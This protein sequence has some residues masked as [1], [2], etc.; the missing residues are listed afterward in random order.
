MAH[1]RDMEERTLNINALPLALKRAIWLRLPMD[2]RLRCAEVCRSWRDA[3]ADASLWTTLDLSCLPIMEV[4]STL[5]LLNAAARR[6]GGQLARLDLCDYFF[7][8]LCAVWGGERGIPA[9]L[10]ALGPSAAS[11][12]E[13]CILKTDLYPGTAPSCA[14][15]E[16]VRELEHA[17]PSLTALDC[18]VDAAPDDAVPLLLGEEPT[19]ALTLRYLK[20][21]GGL[22]TT[23]EAWQELCS[24]VAACASLETLALV[25]PWLDAP[26]ATALVD[27]A[28][29]R[30]LKC[31]SLISCVLPLESAPV[32]ARLLREGQL[33]AFVL[34]MLR[35]APAEPYGREDIAPL[36]RELASAARESR[37]LRSL[38]LDDVGLWRDMRAGKEMLAALTAHPTLRELY[39]MHCGVRIR[40]HD[41]AVGVAL[42]ALVAANSPSLTRLNVRAN[43]LRE[44]ALAPLLAALRGNTHLRELTVRVYQASPE[45]ERD[46]VQPAVAASRG[47]LVVHY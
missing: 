45:F 8:R 17:L 13:L 1:Q 20:T 12:R 9:L 23:V 19:R 2:T 33:E 18:R 32:L 27:C 47:V 14:P 6:A 5:A 3:L 34:C 22:L 15:I 36:L 11:L 44:A 41:R 43:L 25:S 26:A 40:E 35:T 28:L 10:R 30:R 37:T 4:A 38:V 42:A 39:L 24:A 16:Q 31:V 21:D 29:A 7:S 46:V